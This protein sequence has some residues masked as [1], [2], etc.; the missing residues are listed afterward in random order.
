LVVTYAVYTVELTGCI[1]KCNISW[2]VLSV[3]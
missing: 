1:R 3:K 2:M